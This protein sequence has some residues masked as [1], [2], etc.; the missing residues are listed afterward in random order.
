MGDSDLQAR[1]AYYRAYVVSHHGKFRRAM[2]LT[3]RSRAIYDT[4]DRP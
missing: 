1:C 2:E 4:L 3:D